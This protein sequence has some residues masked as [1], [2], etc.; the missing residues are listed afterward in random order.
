MKKV[1][2]YKIIT[3]TNSFQKFQEEVSKMLFL[4]YEF[5][6]DLRVFFPD[7]GGTVYLREIIKYEKEN[8]NGRN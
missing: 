3:H 8:Q 2:D 4:D 5:L 7:S 6:G 1:I